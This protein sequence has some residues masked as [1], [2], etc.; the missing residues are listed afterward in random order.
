MSTTRTCPSCGAA[1]T[2]SE[3]FC[4]NCGTRL[5]EAQ[6]AVA[7]T[8]PLNLPAEQPAPPPTLAPTPEGLRIPTDAVPGGP[9]A[10]PPA[11]RGLPLWGIILLAL[12]GLC[13]ISCAGVAIFVTVVGQQVG[14]AAATAVVELEPTIE[15]LATAEADLQPTREVI[16]SLPTDSAGA[17]GAVGGEAPGAASVLQTAEAATAIAAGGQPAEDV[18]ANASEVFRDEFEDNRNAWFTGEVSDIETDAIEDGVFKVFWSGKGTTYEPYM[19]RELGDFVAELDCKVQQGDVNGAC[20]IIFGHETDVGFYKFEVYEDYY[21]LYIVPS[22]ESAP[23]LIEGDPAEIINR[24]DWN[25]LRVV[26]QGDTIS[27]FLNDTPLGTVSD[28]TYGVG[29]VGVSTASFADEG[30]VEVWFDNFTI[31]ELQ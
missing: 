4:A 8:V 12:A 11:K 27:V 21:S 19:E 26:R 2:E 24:G 7:P 15:A 22:D 10:P 17:G 29:N 31:W 30:G 20:G 23:P 14:S 25:R 5:P 18:F 28:S 6:P 1:A 3:R 9:D 16:L 13:A